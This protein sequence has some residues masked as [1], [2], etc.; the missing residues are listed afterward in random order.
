MLENL[1]GRL[2]VSFCTNS[3]WLPMQTFCLHCSGSAL[4]FSALPLSELSKFSVVISH[5]LSW[6]EWG[7]SALKV[8]ARSGFPK[9]CSM[10]GFFEGRARLKKKLD[11]LKLKGFRANMSI[12]PLATSMMRL[13]A[14]P[15]VS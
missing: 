5:Y 11:R 2:S 9:A 7:S 15:G 10:T 1:D 6:G 3:T 8:R 12:I 13:E 4:G 14:S